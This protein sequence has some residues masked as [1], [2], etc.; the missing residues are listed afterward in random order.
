MNAA[1]PTTT[2]VA[3]R[4]LW[5]DVDFSTMPTTTALKVQRA[6][7]ADSIVLAQ[8]NVQLLQAAAALFDVKFGQ[9]GKAAP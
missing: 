3:E 5:E 8:V 4:D 1:A 7:L 6:M 9:A 2:P